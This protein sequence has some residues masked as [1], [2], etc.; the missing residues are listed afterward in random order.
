MVRTGQIRRIG[1]SGRLVGWIAISLYG[2]VVATTASVAAPTNRVAAPQGPSIGPSAAGLE[3]FEKQVRPMLLQECQSCH[4]PKLQQGG[5]RLD[6]REATLKGGARGPGLV[7]GDPL[8]SWLVRAVHHEDV[9]MPPGKRLAKAKIEALEEWIRLGA[10]WPESKT[11]SGMVLGDQVRI[12]R[13]ARNH[14]AYQPLRKPAVPAVANSKLP[15]RNPIDAFVLARLQKAG[16]APSPP[17]D[18]RTLLRRVTYDLTGLPP[19]AEE[20]DAFLADR[21]HDAYEKVVDRLLASP[22]YGER[23]GRHWLDVA[24]YADTKDGVLQY[25]DARIRPYAYTYRDYVI[26]AL[27][28]D[29]PYDRFV[30]EQLA[31]DQLDLKGEAWRLAAMGF[32]TLGRQYDNNVHD[33]IDDKIDTVSRGLLG[34]TVSCARCHDHKYDAIPIK[35]Y[36][37]LYGVFAASEAPL[38]LPL[39][40]QPEQVPG[41]ADYAKQYEPK[42]QELAAFESKQFTLLSETARERAGDYFFHAATTDPDPLETA[43][44]FLSLDPGDLRP[45]IVARWR[46]LIQR[47]AT[48]DDPLF[49]PYRALADLPEKGFIEASAAVLARLVMRPAGTATGQ[50]NRVVLQALT[51]AKLDDRKAVA[52]VYADLLKQTYQAGKAPSAPAMTP[53]QRQLLELVTSTESPAWFPRNHTYYYM[54]RGEKDAYGGMQQNLDVLAVQQAG[55]PPRAMVLNDSQEL[56]PPRVFTRGNPSTPGETVPRRFLAVLTGTRQPSFNLGSG[57]L[58]MARSITDPRNPL[59]ARVMVNR[60][61]MHHFGE[62]LVATPSDFG[63]RS[64]PPTHP[65]LLDY[66]AARFSA[67]LG[68]GARERGGEGATSDG[69]AWS[70]KKLHRLM[71]NSATYRQSSAL[72]PPPGARASRP[73]QPGVEKHSSRHQPTRS[74]IPHSAF[75]IPQLKDPENRLLW[76]FRR[77]RLD[78]EEMRDTLVAASGRLDRAQFGRALRDAFDPGNRRRTVYALVDRQSL[79]EAFRAFNFAQPDNSVERRPRTIVPQQALFGLNS[80][81]VVEQARALAAQVKG[82]ETDEARVAGLYRALFQRPATSE[83]TRAALAFV[84]ATAGSKSPLNAWEQLAQVLFLTNEMMFVD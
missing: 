35:D 16:L 49:S 74:P 17:A 59:T 60:V 52:R 71:V 39:I 15:A 23:W 34:L 20:A 24:R 29:T 55:A 75:R 69:L 2:G 28:A 68:E 58:E 41:Y 65:E 10:P 72:I 33:Q 64:A 62:P 53:E 83:E 44:F 82:A 3:I 43:I 77:R 84:G 7:P 45:Q 67:P 6:T 38:D 4:G 56:H 31:A 81:F 8:S 18:R 57:R 66:L 19:T 30:Q 13:E 9:V 36:Y 46:R 76:R 14:W 25:G 26:R 42:K 78:F 54:S 51:A 21:S 48:P 47:R 79:P 63:S 80:P 27:N 40:A 22:S 32:L 5:L 70:L 37:S 11:R 50:V 73:H 61:W 1:Q 12:V